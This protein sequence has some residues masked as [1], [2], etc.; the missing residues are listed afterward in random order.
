LNIFQG[1]QGAYSESAARKAYPNCEAV[2]C[3]QFDTAFEVNILL[4][5][6]Q[7]NFFSLLCTALLTRQLRVRSIT[8]DR[9]VDVE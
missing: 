6:V 3:E 1:V 9:R 7:F 2:P 5:L 8:S 4:P